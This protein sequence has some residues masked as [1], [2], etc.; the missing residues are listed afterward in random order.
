MSTEGTRKR[1]RAHVDAATAAAAAATTTTTA[2]APV[3]PR[4]HRAA[5]DDAE[6]EPRPLPP[7]RLAAKVKKAAATLGITMQRGTTGEGLTTLRPVLTDKD[8]ED[9]GWPSAARLAAIAEGSAWL[10]RDVGGDDDVMPFGL[11]LLPSSAARRCFAGI[12]ATSFR[13]RFE[14]LLWPVA[15]AAGGGPASRAPRVG[16]TTPLQQMLLSASLV[17]ADLPTLCGRL[18][19]ELGVHAV[20]LY[21]VAGR[22]LLLV[23]TFGNHLPAYASGPNEVPVFALAFSLP[24]AVASRCVVLW[25]DEQGY[26]PPAGWVDG[27]D[28][29][30]SRGRRVPPAAAHTDD[31][32][33]PTA[34]TVWT[35]GLSATTSMA[36]R[37]AAFVEPS[38]AMPLERLPVTHYA[39]H[40]FA[41]YS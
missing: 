33:P 19:A 15:R 16:I 23:A 37:G 22:L 6:R 35:H 36:W 20:I 30:T 12:G 34:T 32:G 11:E 28:A 14:R 5:P 24:T 21:V 7:D 18:E 40:Y 27:D 25:S 1:T 38:V 4:K 41:F 31:K 39:E 8:V 10:R 29:E 9:V 13:D 3:A 2:Q 17:M 26:T